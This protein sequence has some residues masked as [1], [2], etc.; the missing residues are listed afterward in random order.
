MEFKTIA[1]VKFPIEEVWETM[2]DQLPMLSE[3]L[4]DIESITVQ[5]KQEEQKGNLRV[6]NIWQASPKLPSII[7]DRIKPEMLVWT[8]TAVW[9]EKTLTC[10]W[11]IDPHYFSGK[12]ACQ[13]NTRFEPAI[14]GRGTRITFA[15]DLKIDTSLGVSNMMGDLIS[16][17]VETI[18]VK[19]IPNNF[20]KL[21]GAI[22][23][24]LSEK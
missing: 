4:E 7:A 6:I 14:G 5:D 23:R 11:I 22:T 1:V 3:F 2:R 17:G 9:K 12:V 10:D 16:K 8:D 20:S 18:L 13:G 24:Y 19:V 21:S 15:G